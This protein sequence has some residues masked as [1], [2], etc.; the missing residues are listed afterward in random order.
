MNSSDESWAEYRAGIDKIL[1]EDR[2]PRAGVGEK[3]WRER[4]YGWGRTHIPNESEI[5]RHFA[6]REVDNREMQA[7][8]RANGFLRAYGHGQAVLDWK[9]L[10]A[11]PVKVGDVRVRFDAA[12]PDDV[13]DA[14]RQLEVNAKRQYDEEVL[15]V[16]VMRDLARDARRSGHL[17]VSQLGDLKPFGWPEGDG[18]DL[19][20]NEDEEPF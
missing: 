16:G 17:V 15:L 3:A 5:V 2:P 20:D 13:E 9:L 4:A 7:T 8:K 1:D 14:A 11:L 12:T 19:G 6:V 18:M 10:G